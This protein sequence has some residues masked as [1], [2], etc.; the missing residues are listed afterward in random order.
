MNG[1]RQKG[2]NFTGVVFINYPIDGGNVKQTLEHTLNKVLY[3][4]VTNL[5]GFIFSFN[6][7]FH[8]RNPYKFK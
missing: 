5:K 2:K 3:T 6:S 8:I 1:S 4:I 7:E